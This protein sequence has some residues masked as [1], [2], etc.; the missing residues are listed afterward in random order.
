VISFVE[1]SPFI[2]E[3]KGRKTDSHAQ[4]DNLTAQSFQCHNRRQWH[5]NGV[6]VLSF[7]GLKLAVAYFCSYHADK[8]LVSNGI[9]TVQL[10][11]LY[12]P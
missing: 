7:I 9:L 12:K 6:P 3:I 5:K 2:R 1:I 8:F 10:Q 4:S 11:M